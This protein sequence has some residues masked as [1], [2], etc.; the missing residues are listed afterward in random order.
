M[1][2]EKLIKTKVQE[3]FSINADKYVTS[4][5]HA[6]G[7]DLALLVNWLQPDPNWNVLDIAT[8]GGHATKTLSPHVSHIFATDLT[9]QMLEAARKHLSSESCNNVT[10]LVADA[11]SLPFLDQSFDTVVC[12]IAAHHFPNPKKFVQEV[13]RVLKIDGKF[14]LIDNVSPDQPELDLFINEME[15]LR[16]HSHGRCYTIAEWM[17]W[18]E[19][20]GLQVQQANLRKKKFNFPDWVKR[21]AQSEAQVQTV[22]GHILKASQETLDYIHADIVDGDIRSIQIDEW[23]ALASKN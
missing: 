10:Y 2:N 1:D 17:L 8:G 7:A 14:L 16:D 23:M 19:E 11:E 3:V 20:Y 15:K 6:T 4:H 9:K 13:S 12:R 22:V 5:T 18:F 21:T